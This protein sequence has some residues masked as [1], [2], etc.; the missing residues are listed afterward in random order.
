MKLLVK[1]QSLVKMWTQLMVI[2]CLI[3]FNRMES[4]PTEVLDTSTT[5]LYDGV[6]VQGSVMYLEYAYY[7]Y[8]FSY[9][10][11]VS[12]TPVTTVTR[13]TSSIGS[14]MGSTVND[15]LKNIPKKIPRNVLTESATLAVK[16][17]SPGATEAR[18]ARA[19]ATTDSADAV[20]YD[21]GADIFTDIYEQPDSDDDPDI[22]DYASAPVDYDITADDRFDYPLG[23]TKSPSRSHPS[24]G[25]NG[26]NVLSDTND[27]TSNP[28]NGAYN[29]PNGVNNPDNGVNSPNNGV[30]NDPYDPSDPTKNS[31]LINLQSFSGDADVFVSCFLEPSGDL[32]GYPSKLI[33]HH[34]YSSEHYTDDV[35]VISAA[36]NKN[37][38]LSGHSGVFYLGIFGFALGNSVFSLGVTKYDGVRTV[39]AGLPVSGQVLTGLGMWYRFKLN[40]KTSQEVSIVVTPTSGD[41]DLYVKLGKTVTSSSYRPK[42]GGDDGM[43]ENEDVRDA[44]EASDV[45]DVR[46]VQEGPYIPAS[47]TS[48]DYKSVHMGSQAEVIVI[49]ESDMS[50]CAAS[51]CWVSILVDGYS[52]AD[53]SL[54]VTLL[55]TTVQ[56]VDAVPQYSSVAKVRELA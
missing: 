29:P 16:T 48:Y 26:D 19:A 8:T 51:E 25:D 52:A 4:T 33:G 23:D 45:S 37:C 46:D 28:S 42:V 27:N 9:P 56:L 18:K 1:V 55:D 32:N 41:V 40:D 22:T 38:A 35:V 13:V 6:T 14:T 10:N 21:Y 20:G 7:K 11:S 17:A 15:V 36:D 3:G 5:A 31:I 53:F 24:N 44:S 39:I 50:A 30:Y 54:L 2:G 47:R 12:V 34:N 43:G 49:P